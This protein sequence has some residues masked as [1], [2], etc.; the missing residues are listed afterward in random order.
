MIEAS[1]LSSVTVLSENIDGD[2]TAVTEGSILE[3]VLLQW[4]CHVSGS[5]CAHNA[6]LFEKATLKTHA[7]VLDSIVGPCSGIAE[8]ELSHS[9]MGPMVGFHHQV[10]PT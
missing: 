7:I 5:S 8:G 6:L 3:N 2:R 10:I 4:G 1:T 9:L